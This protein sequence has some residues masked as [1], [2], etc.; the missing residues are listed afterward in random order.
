MES[1][2]VWSRFIRDRYRWGIYVDGE[3]HEFGVETQRLTWKQM[4]EIRD[5]KLEEALN[6]NTEP[7]PHDPYK[8][9]NTPPEGSL[10]KLDD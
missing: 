5:R 4:D 1:V 8:V 6:G 2:K 9:P 7:T 10:E 3:L